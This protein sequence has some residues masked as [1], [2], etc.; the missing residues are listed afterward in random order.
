MQNI[1]LLSTEINSI[2]IDEATTINPKYYIKQNN[3]VK[4]YWHTDYCSTRHFLWYGATHIQDYDYKKKS[5]KI[6]FKVTLWRSLHQNLYF[7]LSKRMYWSTHVVF[8]SRVVFLFYI[9]KGEF[10]VWY[11]ATHIQHYDYEKKIGEKLFQGHLMKVTSSKSV[12]F[13]LKTHEIKKRKW[14]KPLIF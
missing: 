10:W 5:L 12:F 13:S 3:R 14:P 11:G 1:I 6:D 7:L 2:S 9:L 8:K 4:K